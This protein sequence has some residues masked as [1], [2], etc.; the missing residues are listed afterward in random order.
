MKE[1]LD[2]G[3]ITNTHGVRGEVKV[4]PLTDDPKRFE[5]LKSVYLDKGGC[6]VKYTIE[7]VRYHKNAVI[8]KFKE[9]PDMNAAEL[10]RDVFLKVDRKDAVKLPKDTYFICDILGAEVSEENGNKLGV[11]K[12][13]IKTGS[14][15]VYIVAD[16]T[17]KEIL[18]PALKDVVREISVEKGRI[19]VS[20]PKGLLDDED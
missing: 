2:I 11:L 12:N 19:I 5:K 3:K 18:V 20:L 16:D 4:M 17:G 7:S 8:I 10:L 13:I 14:N 15:D 6:L 1:H 9:V